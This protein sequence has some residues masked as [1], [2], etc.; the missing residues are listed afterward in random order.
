[1]L[2]TWQFEAQFDHKYF[3]LDSNWTID[4]LPENL[5]CTTLAATLEGDNQATIQAKHHTPGWHQGHHQEAHS[6]RVKG[7]RISHGLGHQWPSWGQPWQSSWQLHQGEIPSQRR[8]HIRCWGLLSS[9]KSKL[10]FNIFCFW[11]SFP[12]SVAGQAPPMGKTCRTKI[13]ILRTHLKRWNVFF[14]GWFMLRLIP[15][16]GPMYKLTEPIENSWDCF[17]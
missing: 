13:S 12:K 17:A 8:H 4:E 7:G 14:S 2:C 11:G 3:N 6:L 1:M 5:L 9:N 16:I 10:F 15:Q